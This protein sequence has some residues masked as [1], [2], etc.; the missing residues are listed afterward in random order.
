MFWPAVDLLQKNSKLDGKTLNVS[1]KELSL[2][3]LNVLAESDKLLIPEVELWRNLL[4]I[5]GTM[6]RSATTVR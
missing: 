3:E 6:G 1:A 4:T 2:F 5:T